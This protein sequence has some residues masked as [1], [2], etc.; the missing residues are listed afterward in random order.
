MAQ[1]TNPLSTRQA[2][3]RFGFMLLAIVAFGLVVQLLWRSFTTAPFTVQLNQPATVELVDQASGKAAFKD[4]GQTLKGKVRPGTY[5]VTAY[6][7][8]KAALSAIRFEVGR[9]QTNTA[10]LTL[11]AANQPVI[12]AT[13]VL[14]DVR[15][16]TGVVRFREP[17]TGQLFS[18]T[19]RDVTLTAMSPGVT[20]LSRV[21]WWGNRNWVGVNPENMLYSQGPQGLRQRAL[22]ELVDDPRVLSGEQPALPITDLAVNEKGEIILLFNS[23]LYRLDNGLRRATL[24]TQLPANDYSLEFGGSFVA[25]IVAQTNVYE[26]RK[27]AANSQPT[28]SLL[29]NVPTRQVSNLVE[30]G[31]HGAAFS[32]SS[33]RLALVQGDQIVVRQLPSNQIVTTLPGGG[34]P[35]VW[36]GDVLYYSS[37]NSVFAARPNQS[38]VQK[39]FTPT[40]GGI[41]ELATYREQVFALAGTRLITS[42]GSTPGQT[43]PEQINRLAAATPKET[44]E[45]SIVMRWLP[46]SSPLAI[47]STFAINNNPALQARSY[48]R[49]TIRFRNR[50]IEHLRSNGVDVRTVRLVYVPEL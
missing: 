40:E 46:G 31:I 50:A 3:L 19:E 38:F 4:T 24:V 18:L 49:E 33:D 28:A 34:G 23:K 41:N 16:G 30:A 1:Q 36:G 5:T 35:A 32:P 6:T 44:L 20:R 21:E 15:L 2:V 29:I 47:V 14:S 42:A 22:D 43:L 27:E 45:Y 37:N 12:A 9:N 39:L 13:G 7:K 17:S 8:D 25:A 26:D 48:Q 10:T 11:A